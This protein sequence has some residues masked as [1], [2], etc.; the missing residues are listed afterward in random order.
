MLLNL[1][2]LGTATT[3]HSSQNSGSGC[4]LKNP[5]GQM[6]PLWGWS[7]V[8]SRLSWASLWEYLRARITNHDTSVCCNRSTLGQIASIDLATICRISWWIDSTELQSCNFGSLH[9]AS[10]TNSCTLALLCRP[11]Y[12]PNVHCH[13]ISRPEQHC[14]ITLGLKSSQ[15]LSLAR[16]QEISE[17]DLQPEH[18]EVCSP[19][20]YVFFFSLNVQIT[21][22][23]FITFPDRVHGV[24]S[25]NSIIVPG[26]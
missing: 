24:L 4:V 12:H 2:V 10:F 9:L 22:I 23:R 25:Q 14:A 20:G 26:P 8:S 1:F 7:K 3:N 5:S 18:Q 21:S 16:Q 13:C 19:S 6:Y 11:S 15:N 17:K